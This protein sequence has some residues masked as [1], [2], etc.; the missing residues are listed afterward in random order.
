MIFV[1]TFFC[2]IW[3]SC[4]RH[5]LYMSTVQIGLVRLRTC[6]QCSI[7]GSVARINENVVVRDW[8]ASYC[9]LMISSILHLGMILGNN[10][11]NPKACKKQANQKRVH[12]YLRPSGILNA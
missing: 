7:A 12:I 8:L 10:L 5:T 2:Y 9:G 4:S 1:Q 6:A 3:V 11:T